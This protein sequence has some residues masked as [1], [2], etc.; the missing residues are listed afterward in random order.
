MSFSHQ[1]KMG[2]GCVSLTRENSSI[3]D[4]AIK[5]G[6]TCFD[7]AEC[8][9]S[10]ES[11]IALGEKLKN[12]DR[13]KITI[14]SKGGVR[15]TSNGRPEL[16]GSP[17]N[18]VAA[19]EASLKR[20]QTNYLDLYYLHRIDPQTEFESSITA[21]KELV[22]A[23]KI[24]GIGLS[25]VTADQIR[26]AHKIHPV[27]AVQIEYAPWSRE[28][29][30]ND[31]IST[32]AELKIPVVAYSPL[33]RAFFTDETEAYFT[34]MPDQDFRRL[35]P[36]YSG[37]DLKQNCEAKRALQ[38][39]A[40]TKSCSLAQLILAW[41]IHKGF[42]PIPATT[43][44]KHLA[45]NMGALKVNLTSDE[46]NELNKLI[47]NCQFTGPRYPSKDISAIHPEFRRKPLWKNPVLIGAS[48]LAISLFGKVLRASNG[49]SAT[50]TMHHGK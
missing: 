50:E 4:E 25:E 38:Q 48:I 49:T 24:N 13:K 30:S 22:E 10:N 40:K 42:I 8:Y 11:E 43:N 28:D 29:E 9:G 3:I 12:Y 37:T 23:K 2:L 36:R 5:N 35:L 20:L 16:D 1:I 14:C 27:S 44:S 45:E 15:F 21:L 17:K 39:F 41:E 34:S 18:L 33:G 46:M 19:C 32:C 26:R 47:A 31:V 7:T 6:L